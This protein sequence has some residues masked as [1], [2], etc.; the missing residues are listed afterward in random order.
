MVDARTTDAGDDSGTVTCALPATGEHCLFLD[1]CTRSGESPSHD[2]ACEW[3]C[4]DGQTLDV[5]LC[6]SPCELDSDCHV[7]HDY[8]CDGGIVVRNNAQQTAAPDCPEDVACEAISAIPYCDEGTCALLFP[9]D[10]RGCFEGD[11]CFWLPTD[12]PD[13]TSFAPSNRSA[14]STFR[15]RYADDSE[16]CLAN[17]SDPNF[18]TCVEGQCVPL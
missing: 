2:D 16:R 9:E 10:H 17:N 4:P 18:P 14:M 15:S 11:E 12:Y 8:C 13:C 7:S 3:F 5:D 1:D 6:E